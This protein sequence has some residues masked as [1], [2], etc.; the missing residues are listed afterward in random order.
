MLSVLFATEAGYTIKENN[1]KEKSFCRVK[2]PF[3]RRKL[4]FCRRKLKK[5]FFASAFSYRG[6]KKSQLQGLV[7]Y[8]F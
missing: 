2:L 1:N 7:L 5:T 6:K 8:I 4:A 3:C